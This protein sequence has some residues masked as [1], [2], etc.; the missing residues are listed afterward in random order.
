[1]RR[2][3]AEAILTAVLGT[4]LALVSGRAMAADTKG[5]IG[6]KGGLAPRPATGENEEALPDTGVPYQRNIDRGAAK[7]EEEKPWEVGATFETHRS[8]IQD[9][10]VSGAPKVSNVFGFYAVYRLGE[11]DTLSL[12]QYFTE[13]FVV[14]QGETGVRADDTALAFTHSLA[15]P[16][17]FLFST[18]VSVTAPTSLVAQK[19][20][21]ITAPRLNLSLAKRFGRYIN[22]GLN[23]GGGVWIERYAEAEGGAANPLAQVAGALSADVT[24]P[25]HEPL[26]IGAS[27]S[28]GYFWLYNIP[29]ANP[30]V[31]D[32]NYINQ[33]VTQTYGAE[34]HLRY[35]LPSL[36]GV[37][38]DLTLAVDEG[39][40]GYSD[41]YLHDGVGYL[42]L[43]DR[44]TTE[45]YASFT[46]RY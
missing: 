32:A 40:P 4:A 1:M 13:N 18:T 19:E 25:F 42:Y 41:S 21:L 39:G 10:L 46:A 2:T 12:R 29:N 28:T 7:Q 36:A 11:S 26:S 17:D 45:G 9:D 20:G 5:D 16:R 22:L 44:E 6:G 37:K 14:D 33:P 23:I 8:F 31:A 3:K 27:A 24:M 43:F 15:L 30:S 34:A 38:S 35:Q